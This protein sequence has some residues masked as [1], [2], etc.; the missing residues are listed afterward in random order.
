MNPALEQ[1]SWLDGASENL[2]KPLVKTRSQEH[3]RFIGT[4]QELAVKKVA[5][6]RSVG[7]NQPFGIKLFFLVRESFALVHPAYCLYVAVFLTT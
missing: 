7:W 1:L 5:S 3:R 6:K 4:W 2:L